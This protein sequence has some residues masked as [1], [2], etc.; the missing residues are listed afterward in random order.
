MNLTLSIKQ[1]HLDAILAGD[2]TVEYRDY[3]DF[4]ISRLCVLNK[5]DE[6]KSWKPIETVTFRVGRK[7]DSPTF[8]FKVKRLAFEEWLDEKTGAPL[9]EYTFA[10][11]LG[12]RVNDLPRNE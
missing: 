7:K 1:E 9:D 3:T 5:K 2:K 6:F 12:A 11:Y 10:I 8:T 4:Y